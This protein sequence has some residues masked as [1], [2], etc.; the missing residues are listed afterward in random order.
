MRGS[1]PKHVSQ[2]RIHQLEYELGIRDD[3]PSLPW[4]PDHDGADSPGTIRFL[5]DGEMQ[6]LRVA[7]LQGATA[8]T[9]KLDALQGGGQNR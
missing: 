4:E 6:E 7:N 1:N 2:R 9:K 3:E 5:V 8:F